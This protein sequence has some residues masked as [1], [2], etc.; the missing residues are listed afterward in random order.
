MLCDVGADSG[1]VGPI[2]RSNSS[3]HLAADTAFP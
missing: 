1:K 2:I 3:G